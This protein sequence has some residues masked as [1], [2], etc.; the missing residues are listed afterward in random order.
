MKIY[1]SHRTGLSTFTRR[2]SPSTDQSLQKNFHLSHS[3]KIE[4]KKF[5][6]PSKNKKH[7]NTPTK[8]TQT[9]TVERYKDNGL[10]QRTEI[11]PTAKT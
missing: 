11:R 7:A 8:T 4:L 3:D 6:S 10:Q 2:T 1:N 5:A 9:M